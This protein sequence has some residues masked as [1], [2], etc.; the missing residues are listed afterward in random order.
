VPINTNLVATNVKYFPVKKVL[1]LI[2]VILIQSC[3]LLNQT[4]E[5]ERF[6]NSTFSLKAVDIIELGGV[7]MSEISEETK[8]NVGDI[9]TLTGRLF[10]GNMPAKL[11]ATVEVKNNTDKIAAISGMDWIFMKDEEE[12][13]RGVVDERVEVDPYKTKDFK[14]KA[15][16]DLKKILK[17]ESLPQILN[18]VFNMK[19][20]SV[21]SDMGIVLKIK[22]YYKSGSKVK[23]YP[24]YISLKP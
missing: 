9:M 13:A 1:F 5:Y 17:L 11:T 7:D 8:L 15:D 22:P 14:V 16:I 23:K 6:V 20:P 2:V 18:L 19:D 3:G 24:A 4:G 12:Y 10:S 21:L